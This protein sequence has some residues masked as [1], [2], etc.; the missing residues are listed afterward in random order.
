MKL[1]ITGYG[2]AAKNDIIKMIPKI[3]NLPKET[4]QDDEIDAIAIALSCTS[5][6]TLFTD[7]IFFTCEILKNV[8]SKKHKVIN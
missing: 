2:R 5:G 8:K 3:V 6:N 1:A 4:M 7:I